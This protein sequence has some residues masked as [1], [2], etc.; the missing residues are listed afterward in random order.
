MGGDESG[1]GTKER[2]ERN[3][4]T[5]KGAWQHVMQKAFLRTMQ[6]VYT[7]LVGWVDGWIVRHAGSGMPS[8]EGSRRSRCCGSRWLPGPH[9]APNSKRRAP[10]IGAHT[11][12]SWQRGLLRFCSTRRPCGT[13]SAAPSPPT[14]APWPGLPH[15]HTP[16]LASGPAAPALS[17]AGKR[18]RGS[19]QGAGRADGG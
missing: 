1:S 16:R 11:A 3:R 4:K 12:Q 15:T 8:Q 10:G 18:R 9:A 19:G 2:L 14:P 17:A 13:L 6:Q 7:L 5:G